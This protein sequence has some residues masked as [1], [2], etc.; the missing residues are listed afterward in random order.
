[1]NTNKPCQ[2]YDDSKWRVHKAA[3]VWT[4]D[5][6]IAVTI[7]RASGDRWSL[8]PGHQRPVLGVSLKSSLAIECHQAQERFSAFRRAKAFQ[9]P[10]T[11]LLQVAKQE[12]SVATGSLSV[13]RHS[14]YHSQFAQCAFLKCEN[15]EGYAIFVTTIWVKKMCAYSNTNK[16]FLDLLE[17][18]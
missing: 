5:D 18:P 14:A 6:T 13:M 15:E 7:L 11:S 2:P 16:L 4:R 9:T 17:R 10:F 12:G 3:R 1:M 8:L